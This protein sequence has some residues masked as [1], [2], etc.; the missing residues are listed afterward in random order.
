MLRR[1]LMNVISSTVAGLQCGMGLKTLYI[2][3]VGA[4][5]AI[6]RS[7][8]RRIHVPER[9]N[10]ASIPMAKVLSISSQVAHGYVGNSA[11]A[12]V[13]QRMGHEVLSLPT[14]LL[15]NRPGYAAIAGKRID[16]ADLHAMLEA[17][18]A[19]GWLHGIDAVMTGYLP[20]PAHA[21]LCETW[22]ARIKALN[23]KALYLCDPIVGDEPSGL[24]VDEEAANA[25]RTALAPIAD[26]ITPNAFELGWLSGRAASNLEDVVAAARSLARPAVLVTSAPVAG[27]HEI[28]NV[29]VEGEHT[30]AAVSPRRSLSAHG[31][32][33]FLAAI[34]LAHRLNGLSNAV[35]LRASAAAI[36][37]IVDCCGGRAELPL[38]ETQAQWAASDPLLATA[39]PVI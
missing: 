7:A 21:R 38:I 4:V 11:A 10:L 23:P 15:S 26:I 12:F 2:G 30:L 25:I 35:A 17:V 24:Y 19:N 13:L 16:P 5:L 36:E 39:Q 37:H 22:L 18:A 14:I 9:R 28:A 8:V 29:L 31:T 3:S 33:D 20:S 34:F 32:G 6:C 27:A 1:G